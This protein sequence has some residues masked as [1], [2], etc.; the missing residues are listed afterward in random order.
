M[1][2]GWIGP[3]LIS[4]LSNAATRVVELLIPPICPACGAALKQG[5][6][7]L[8][9]ACAWNLATVVGGNYC[10][11]CGDDSGAHLLIEGRCFTCRNGWHPRR[12]DGFIRVGIY[13]E[14]LRDLILRF[15]T[16][17]VLDRLLGD[18]LASAIVGRI[19]PTEVDYWVPIP[20]HWRRRLNVGFQPTAL[21]ARGAV[22]PWGGQFESLLKATRYIP[23]FHRRKLSAADRTKEI[24]GVFRVTE[25]NRVKGQTICL[26]DDVTT[27][28]ATLAEARSVLRKAGASRVFAAVLAK[29]S[30]GDTA[31][32]GSEMRANP[33]H[34]IAYGPLHEIH[35]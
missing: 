18:M 12:F 17:Y 34:G 20:S 6:G 8:C 1:L 13:R 15:K 29:A 16:H 5:D 28:G 14:A 4:G 35:Q 33:S 7:R 9:A 25:P 10:H 24:R 31:I 32:V 3:R 19:N 2:S 21:L 27:T 22:A 11:A 30:S 23:P 26:I